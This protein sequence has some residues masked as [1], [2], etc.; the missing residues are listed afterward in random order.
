ME[1]C[2]G[3]CEPSPACSSTWILEPDLVG[4]FQERSERGLVCGGEKAA[5][6]TAHHL[7]Q[8]AFDHPGEALV[9]VENRPSAVSV[10]AP[11]FMDSMSTR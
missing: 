8:R 11:S 4:L 6:G 9:G 5:K 3:N 7:L 10:S 2:T 1:I